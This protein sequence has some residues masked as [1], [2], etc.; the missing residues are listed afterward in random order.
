MI[1]TDYLLVELEKLSVSVDGLAIN[2]IIEE[3]EFILETQNLIDEI[4]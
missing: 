3:K 4:G 1:K 2:D